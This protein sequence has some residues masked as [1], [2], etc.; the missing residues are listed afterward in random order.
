[1]K[2]KLKI[3]TES[4]PERCEV[5]HQIDLF[6]PQ[7]GHCSRCNTQNNLS[8]IKLKK[9]PY[10]AEEIKE[11]AIKCRYCGSS[12]NIITPIID[13]V[14]HPRQNQEIILFRS[15]ILGS[16]IFGTMGLFYGLILGHYLF[17]GLIGI[18]FGLII[19]FKRYERINEKVSVLRSEVLKG[20]LANVNIILSSPTCINFKGSIGRTVLIDAVEQGHA[21]IVKILLYAGA[22]VKVEDNDGNTALK[23][24]K[25]AG[26]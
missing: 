17:G 4:L 5:C 7:T 18:I 2:T 23:L 1:M 10:C 22:D 20:N 9:C 14:S 11:E 3:R 19:G 16:V 25:R 21:E 24:A 12:L 6:D 13:E 26:F 15:L 8:V